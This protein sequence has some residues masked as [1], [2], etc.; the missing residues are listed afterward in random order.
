LRLTDSMCPLLVGSDHTQ[1]SSGLPAASQRDSN[2]RL[3]RGVHHWFLDQV[4]DEGLI[5]TS[6]VE[7]IKY[8]H[9]DASGT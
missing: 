8:M 9:Q 7:V 1:P 6:E 2:T 3:T 5:A 4:V